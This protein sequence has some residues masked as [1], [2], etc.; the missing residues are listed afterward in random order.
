MILS[1]NEILKEISK[2][3]IEIDPFQEENVGPC[4]VDFRLGT[5]FRIFKKQESPISIDKEFKVSDKFTKTVAIKE[6]K[7]LELK[8]G[9]FVLGTTL[10]RLKLPNDICARIEGRST[11]ARIG[12]MVHISSALIQPTVNNIQVLEIANMSP[13]TLKL[14]PGIRICQILFESLKGKAEYKGQFKTQRKP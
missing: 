2:K 5:I 9:E 6:G 11:F 14:F 10:E 1:K 8:P 12:L 7:F 4:S 3:R 13:Y